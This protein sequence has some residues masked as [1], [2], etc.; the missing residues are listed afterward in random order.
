M[1]AIVMAAQALIA[2]LAT[3]VS[4]AEAPATIQIPGDHVF[5]ESLTSSIDGTVYVGSVLMGAVFRAPPGADS[6]S[7]WVAPG[8]DGLKSVFGVYADDGS[9]TLWVCSNSLDPAGHAPPSHGELHAF[10]LHSGASKGNYPFPSTDAYCNDIAVGGDGE[11]YAT[12]SNAME[13]VRLSPGAK[14]LSVWTPPGA[15][16]ANGGLLDG[17]SVLGKS[18]VVNTYNTGK[19]FSVRVNSDGSAG[20]VKEITLSRPIDHPDGMRAFG[21]HA[22]LII[23]GGGS[24][25][26]SKIVFKGA[27]GEVSSV[28]QGYPDGAVSVTQVGTLAYVV[29]SHFKALMS[30][31][32]GKTNAFHATAVEV[33][34]P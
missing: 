28:K 14:Q 16:G 22:V 34:R 6:A 2:V 4:L 27:K 10:D 17:I 5:P 8:A 33:G 12:D 25:A 30:G 3:S 24:G 18:I 15:F 20:P 19:V 9:Q 26:L 11:V 23:E 31:P 32:N 29:E 7:V 21:K 1:W 13:V